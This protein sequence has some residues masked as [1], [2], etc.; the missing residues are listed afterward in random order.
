MSEP[1]TNVRVVNKTTGEETGVYVR[2]AGY[3][4]GIAQWDV[5]GV[6]TWFHWDTHRFTVDVIPAHTGLRFPKLP[7]APE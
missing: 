5:I 6:P 4:D 2:W 3:D 7:G 1:P